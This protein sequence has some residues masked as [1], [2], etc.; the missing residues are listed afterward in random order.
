MTTIDTE[1]LR[2]WR[3]LDAEFFAIPS[4]YQA[5]QGPNG[6]EAAYCYHKGMSVADAARNL[7]QQRHPYRERME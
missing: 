4:Q 5:S 3:A 2:F 6:R 1:F 7:Y